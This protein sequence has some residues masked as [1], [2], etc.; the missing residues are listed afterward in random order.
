MDVGSILIAAVSLGLLGLVF[1]VILA[2]ASRAFA[3]EQ[4]ERIPSIIDSLPGANCGGCGYAGCAAYAAAIAD[5]SASV[6]S[7]PVG[8]EASAAKIAAIM[9]VTAVASVPMRANVRCCGADC[10]TQKKYRYE[11]IADCTAVMRLGGGEKACRYACTGLGSCVQACQ[12]EAIS[13]VDGVAFVDESLCTGCGQCLRACPK[14]LI[15]LTPLGQ[16][17]YV[18]CSNRDRGGE[19]KKVCSVGCIGCNLCEKNCPADA[20]HVSDNFAKID[21]TKCTSCGICA[22]KCPTKIIRKKGEALLVSAS[23]TADAPRL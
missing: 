14:G 21:Y 9:G 19:T 11:G 15:T 12:F 20:I 6:G 2:V 13:L 8:G 4:D 18:G 10:D 23:Q 1:G 5:G 17:Y 22:E 16:D 7:C 3:V